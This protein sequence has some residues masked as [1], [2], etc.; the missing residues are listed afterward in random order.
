MRFKSL[1]ASQTSGPTGAY[2][3][4]S[5]QRTAFL[6]NGTGQACLCPLT[7]DSSVGALNFAA[8]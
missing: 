3:Q 1:T 4:T 8:L 7:I 2:L 5:G 6:E